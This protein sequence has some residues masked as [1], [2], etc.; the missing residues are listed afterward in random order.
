MSGFTPTP[1]DRSSFG[2][3]AAGWTAPNDFDDAIHAPLDL[4]EADGTAFERLD[5][6]AVQ[7]LPD[8][9]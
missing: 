7:H 4:V 6:L 3:W 5:Q 8:V 1:Q 2:S 9:R